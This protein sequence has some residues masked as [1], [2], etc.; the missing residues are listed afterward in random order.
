MIKKLIYFFIFSKKTIFKPKKKKY[1][2]FDSDDSEIILKYLNKE[3]TEVMDMR[4][5]YEKNQKLNLYV[6]FLIF[7][8]FKFSL[9]HYYNEYINI[10]N[11]KI[12]ITL[13]DNY[14]IFYSFKNKNSEMKKII[15]QKAFRT[16]LP[17]DVLSQLKKLKKNKNNYCDY[18]LMF[19]KGI[20]KIYNSFLNGKVIPVGSFKSNSVAKKKQKKKIG[21]LY[22]SVFRKH[23]KTKSQDIVFFKNLKKYCEKKKN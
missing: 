13:T 9:R 11:P 8:K 21:L 7:L 15:I 23:Q 22:I 5:A 16:K 12:L 3:N 6:L 10:V 4:M 14:P 20:G 1:L 18:L 19:N 2:I 17:S